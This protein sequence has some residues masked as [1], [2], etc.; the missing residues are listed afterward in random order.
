MTTEGEGGGG[1]KEKRRREREW[2]ERMEE[3]G[4]G[5]TEGASLGYYRVHTSSSISSRGYDDASR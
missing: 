1:K 4:G 2:E 5:Y 3:V